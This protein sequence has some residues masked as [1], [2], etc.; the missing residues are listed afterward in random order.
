MECP[1]AGTTLVF[2]AIIRNFVTLAPQRNRCIER[3]EMSVAWVTKVRLPHS[4][5]DKARVQPEGGACL[6]HMG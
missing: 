4:P 2:L 5:G 1:T 3:R 6:C